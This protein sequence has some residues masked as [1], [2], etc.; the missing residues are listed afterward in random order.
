MVCYEVNQ[1]TILYTFVY[2]TR[3]NQLNVC[4]V[5]I[6]DMCDANYFTEMLQM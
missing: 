2:Y 6:Y 3:Q 1:Y 5:S 4:F